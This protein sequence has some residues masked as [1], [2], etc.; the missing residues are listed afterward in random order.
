LR[1]IS[2]KLATVSRSAIRGRCYAAD[3]AT[4][5]IFGRHSNVDPT[6]LGQGFRSPDVF[7]ELPTVGPVVVAVVLDCHLI[8]SHPISS[9]ATSWPYSS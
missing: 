6:E 1:K 9:T 3:H 7:V 8:C 5:R 4:F 2:E